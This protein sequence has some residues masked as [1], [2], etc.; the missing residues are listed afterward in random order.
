[1]VQIVMKRKVRISILW[2]ICSVKGVEN[3]DT[4]QGQLNENSKINKFAHCVW[5]IG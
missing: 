1:M 4:L 3:H 2:V 5:N